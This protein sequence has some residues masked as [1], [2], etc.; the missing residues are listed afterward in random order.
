MRASRNRQVAHPDY[1]QLTA[2][3]KEKD[4]M[5]TFIIMGVVFIAGYLFGFYRCY[6][7]DRKPKKFLAACPE[8]EL[9]EELLA[10][11]HCYKKNKIA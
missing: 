10:I 1:R 7:Y 4:L 6:N 9:S 11:Q 3:N 2:T 5:K 8:E